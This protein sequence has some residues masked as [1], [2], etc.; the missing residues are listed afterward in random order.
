[1]QANSS[2]PAAIPPLKQP[3]QSAWHLLLVVITIVM[4]ILPLV[5][6]SLHPQ[7]I[8]LSDSPRDRAAHQEVRPLL[9]TQIGLPERWCITPGHAPHPVPAP[10][11][12]VWIALSL[13]LIGFCVMLACI[14]L[15]CSADQRMLQTHGT[16]PTPPPRTLLLS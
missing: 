14:R 8:L 12:N 2:R 1:M 7:T 15:C 11:L 5:L 9:M 4:S 6:V 16:P 3:S 13:A 10:T